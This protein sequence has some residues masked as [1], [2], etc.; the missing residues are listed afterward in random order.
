MVFS[1][2]AE[3]ANHVS[4]AVLVSSGQISSLLWSN[5]SG[6]FRLRSLK[7]SFKYLQFTLRIGGFSNSN[8]VWYSQFLRNAEITFLM[9]YWLVLVKSAPYCGQT[10]QEY[11]V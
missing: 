6:I 8:Y 1:I 11:F 7:L 9:L 5:E 3:Y 10:N 2:F 4:N